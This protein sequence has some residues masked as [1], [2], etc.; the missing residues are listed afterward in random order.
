MKTAK[1]VSGPKFLEPLSFERSRPGRSGASVPH[2]IHQ[3]A[4][5]VVVPRL[6][7]VIVCDHLL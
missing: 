6:E 1:P 4:V 5:Q 3:A 7:S 2:P